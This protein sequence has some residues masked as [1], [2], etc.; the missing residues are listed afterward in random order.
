MTKGFVILTRKDLENKDRCPT[1]QS[2]VLSEDD[3]KTYNVPLKVFSSHHGPIPIGTVVGV[4]MRSKCSVSVPYVAHDY[5][6]NICSDVKLVP[7]LP[8]QPDSNNGKYVVYQQKY[9]RY[10]PV[11]EHFFRIL[12]NHN[13]T[14]YTLTPVYLDG[15][16]VLKK[17]FDCRFD[18]KIWIETS[19]IQNREFI[20]T[21]YLEKYDGK[22]K[23]EIDLDDTYVSSWKVQDFLKTISNDAE[24]DVELLRKNIP[25]KHYKNIITPN[26]SDKT[27]ESWMV[28][29]DCP[30]YRFYEEFELHKEALCRILNSDE[31]EAIGSWE[32]VIANSA[33]LYKAACDV[34]GDKIEIPIVYRAYEC[35]H[36]CVSNLNVSALKTISKNLIFRVYLPD[37]NNGLLSAKKLGDWYG[38]N[39]PRAILGFLKPGNIIRYTS[40]RKDKE[41]FWS[42]DYARIIFKIDH[43]RYFVVRE[44]A[45]SILDENINFILDIRAILEIPLE[46]SRNE[47]LSLALASLSPPEDEDSEEE[48]TSFNSQLKNMYTPQAIL[49]SFIELNY[50]GLIWL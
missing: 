20:M 3:E 1:Y 45:Y 39:L 12:K 23:H 17:E 24:I 15:G 34:I 40:G 27:P 38:R 28:G 26:V 11:Y 46:W 49:G 50:D 22:S 30:L 14:T 9:F 7:E 13:N 44:D 18:S 35:E 41:S 37:P 47:N 42:K 6:D 10:F 43:Q 21:E 48:D 29:I 32:R 36:L 31:I 8:K 33:S 5:E 2:F 16:K 25:F 19:F 4:V